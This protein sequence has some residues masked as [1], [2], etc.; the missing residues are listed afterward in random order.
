MAARKF[1]VDVASLPDK[2]FR[3]LRR[4][5]VVETVDVIGGDSQIV[6]IAGLPASSAKRRASMPSI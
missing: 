2:L 4:L 1:S 6:H 3:A 5:N